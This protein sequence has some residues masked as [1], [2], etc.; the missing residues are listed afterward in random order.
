MK[1]AG[2]RDR[3]AGERSSKRS[4]KIKTSDRVKEKL[5]FAPDALQCRVLDTRRAAGT[6]RTRQRFKSTVT[7]AKAV[8]QAWRERGSLTIVI[9]PTSRESG[10]FVRK[11]AEFARRLQIKPKGDGDNEI[12]LQ[13]PNGSRIVGLPGNEADGAEDFFCVAA[14]RRRGFAGE[15]RP[16]IPLRPM[17]AASGGKLADDVSQARFFGRPGSRGGV[18][19]GAD[20]G[21]RRRNARADPG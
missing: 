8:H 4:K 13:F 15:R 18:R 7:A 5:G 21:G 19:V 9:N 3:G 12:S 20:T 17:L 2:P 1:H 14:P 16:D 11:A 6:D 10:E